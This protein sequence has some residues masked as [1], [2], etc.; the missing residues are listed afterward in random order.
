MTYLISFC[1]DK[2]SSSTYLLIGTLDD[3]VEIWK[4]GRLIPMHF[5]RKLFQLRRASWTLAICCILLIRISTCFSIY[6]TVNINS[7]LHPSLTR[8]VTR[9]QE[10]RQQIPWTFT[11]PP[12]RRLDLDLVQLLNSF[13]DL[14][15]TDLGG[16]HQFAVLQM[17]RFIANSQ[18][19]L[20]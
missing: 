11:Q 19:E 17:L 4:L 8:H 6:Y 18:T 3:P 14:S 1:K 10:T 20:T 9:S 2:A 16:D 7:W 5:S 15:S 13:D 12:Q